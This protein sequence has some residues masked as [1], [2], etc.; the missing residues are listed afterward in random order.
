MHPSDSKTVAA[1]LKG[2]SPSK[3]DLTGSS[4]PKKEPKRECKS[5]AEMIEMALN[6]YSGAATYKDITDWIESNLTTE[7][8]DRRVKRKKNFCHLIPFCLRSIEIVLEKIDWRC[9]QF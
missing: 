6:N 9:S 1:I 4:P 2:G 8:A 3:G 5:Y 7:I